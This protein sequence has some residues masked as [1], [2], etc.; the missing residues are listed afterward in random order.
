MKTPSKIFL[1]FYAKDK[2][3]EDIYSSKGPKS[4]F[5]IFAHALQHRQDYYDK[6]KETKYI[7]VKHEEIKKEKNDTFYTFHCLTKDEMDNIVNELD[8]IEL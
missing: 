3:G 4:V 7:K 5:E 2:Y 6:F 1:T 8:N